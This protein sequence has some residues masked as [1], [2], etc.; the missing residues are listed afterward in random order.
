[1]VRAVVVVLIL[2]S[3]AISALCAAPVALDAAIVTVQGEAVLV[4]LRGRDADIDPQDPDAHRMSITVLEGPNH[5]TLSGDASAVQYIPPNIAL[6]ELLYTPDESFTGTDSLVFEVADPAG[7]MDIAEI[8]VD[9]QP[10]PRGNPEI[11]GT[12]SLSSTY[13]STAA[14]PLTDVILRASSVVNWEGFALDTTVDFRDAMFEGLSVTATV[15][16]EDLGSILATIGFD[17]TDS[18]FSYLSVATNF[19]FGDIGLRHVF[20]LSI[21]TENTYTEFKMIG[22]VGLASVSNT[23]TLSGCTSDFKSNVTRVSWGS[24][25][26]DARLTATLKMDCEDGFEYFRLGMSGYSLEP[27]LHLPLELE[28]ELTFEPQEKSMALDLACDDLF[29][30]CLRLYC[31]AVDEDPDPLTSRNHVELY[32]IEIRCSLDPYIRF[33]GATSLVEEKNSAVTGRSDYFEVYTLSGTFFS[34]CDLWSVWQVNVFF[35]RDSTSLFDVGLIEVSADI[36]VARSLGLSLDLTHNAVSG[37]TQLI[38]GFN[39]S[40]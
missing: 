36:S 6:L 11:S 16:F 7:N 24:V 26:C 12:L 4:P 8:R 33:R 9:V 14:S 18:S 17:P 37:Q 20:Y 30:D 40:W 27:L 28:L 23:L 19:S 2:S 25:D 15:N 29:V 21:P 13:D 10:P 35:D 32:G 1:M 39:I 38:T 34:C 22:R 5:G 3:V 31:E